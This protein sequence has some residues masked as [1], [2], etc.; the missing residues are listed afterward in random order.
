MLLQDTVVSQ[1]YLI[2]VFFGDINICDI[3]E[4]C[5]ISI[6][7][8]KSNSAGPPSSILMPFKMLNYG[9]EWID[10]Y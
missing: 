7:D 9:P 5:I 1:I 8:P 6:L 4:Y 2:F 10:R 3:D